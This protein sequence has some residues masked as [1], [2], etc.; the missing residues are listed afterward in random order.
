MILH[1]AS[2]IGVF[3]GSVDLQWYISVSLPSQYYISFRSTYILVLNFMVPVVFLF[4]FTGLCII[5]ILELCTSFV[6]V[7]SDYNIYIYTCIFLFLSIFF[8]FFIHSC[9]YT[10]IT[11]VLL[12][13][14]FDLKIVIKSLLYLFDVLV[15]P[16]K[17]LYHLIF[18]HLYSLHRLSPCRMLS[19]LLIS[20]HTLTV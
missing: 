8:F 16:A 17:Q 14:D 10:S 11:F 12:Q 1:S 5:S 3:L 2:F 20:Y 19:I 13:F 6:V 18:L 4:V 9:I 7:Y 15:N